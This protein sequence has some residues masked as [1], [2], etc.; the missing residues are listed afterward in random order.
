MTGA[1]PAPSVIERDVLEPAEVDALAD[2]MG[3][4]YGAAVIVGAWCYLR[5]SELL[6]LERRDVDLDAGL[7]H[8]RGTKTARSRRSVP[9]PLRA[10]QALATVP[11]RIDTRLLFPAPSGG[12]YALG[13]FRRRRFDWAAGAAGL[14]ESTTPYSLRHSGISWALAVGIP[15]T[16]VAR[17][18]GT[19]VAMLER[20]YAHLLV[21]SA[22]TARA[23]MD[24]LSAVAAEATSLSTPDGAP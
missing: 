16:D 11:A 23:R 5:P 9:V 4:P 21:T 2:E 3:S 7:L 13:N 22:E 17:F 19:S 18:G 10:R 8:V 14:P 15:P 12:P 20:T 24:A 1:N 6:G